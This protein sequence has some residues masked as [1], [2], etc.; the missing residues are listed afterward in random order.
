MI[1]PFHTG[2]EHQCTVAGA[3]NLLEHNGVQT[4]GTNEST[5]FLLPLNSL[6]VTVFLEIAGKVESNATHV[7]AYKRMHSL[8]GEHR[9]ASGLNWGPSVRRAVELV[10]RA[11]CG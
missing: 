9:Q 10:S 7:G 4:G 3:S 1:P 8:G 11:T 5:T 6:N 2:N